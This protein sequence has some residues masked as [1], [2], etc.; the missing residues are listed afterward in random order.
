MCFLIKKFD[1][2]RK[3]L[4]LNFIVLYV[5]NVYNLFRVPLVFLLISQI[6]GFLRLNGQIKS[7][8]RI[9]GFVATLICL[10]L[11]VYKQNSIIMYALDCKVEHFWFLVDKYF[12]FYCLKTLC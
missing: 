6:P 4:N 11:F 1:Y 2:D 10:F 9:P 7:F 12:K 5:K 8:S 3:F